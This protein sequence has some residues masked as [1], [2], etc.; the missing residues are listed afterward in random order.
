MVSW[1]LGCCGELMVMRWRWVQGE[2]VPYIICVDLAEGS[3]TAAGSGGSKGLA[4]R[5][6]HMDEI[7]APGSQLVPDA[8]YYLGHQVQHLIRAPSCS[9]AT[10]Q[11]PHHLLSS[12][13][14]LCAWVPG[15]VP[16]W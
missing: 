14:Q 15:E 2:T 12:W 10:S 9:A 5:A 16:Q 11:S 13:R 6:Y 8:A 7:R 3:D 4:Q 1:L